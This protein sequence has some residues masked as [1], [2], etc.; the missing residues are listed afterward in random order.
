MKGYEFRFMYRGR[1]LHV[2]TG[3]E[4]TR[5]TLLSGDG[6]VL[7]LGDTRHQLLKEGDYVCC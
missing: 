7:W 2:R 3:R 1:L 5:V 4:G 6:V